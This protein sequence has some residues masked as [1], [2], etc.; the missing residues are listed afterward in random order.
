LENDLV[1]LLPHLCPQCLPWKNNACK[2]D[3]DALEGTESLVYVLSS[4]AHEAESVKDGSLE[5]ADFGEFGVDMEGVSISTESIKD[6]LVFGGL[7]LDYCVRLPHWGLVGGSGSSTVCNLGWATEVSGT[8][9][10]DG[11]LVNKNEI[12]SRVSSLS[13]SNDNGC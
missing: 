11:K 9:D 4:D 13:P 1:A 6:G 8:T 10:E 7:L 3:L 5:A 12:A 2:A